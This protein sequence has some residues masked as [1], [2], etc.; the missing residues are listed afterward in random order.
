M[1]QKLIEDTIHELTCR[2]RYALTS[3][4]VGMTI[5]AVYPDLP[6]AEVVAEM[7]GEHAPADLAA[8]VV[9]EVG[10]R[11]DLVIAVPLGEAEAARWQAAAE[12]MWAALSAEDPEGDDQASPGAGR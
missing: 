4:N 10:G 9:M 6:E 1:D 2:D 3:A 7:W 8:M 5:R 11:S 12:C